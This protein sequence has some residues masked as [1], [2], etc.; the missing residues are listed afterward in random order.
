ME[1]QI[2]RANNDDSFE[3]FKPKIPMAIDKIK[4]KKNVQ[5]SKLFIIS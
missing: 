2:E 3:F 1:Q 4:G 5:I